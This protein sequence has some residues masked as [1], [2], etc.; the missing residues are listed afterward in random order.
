METSTLDKPWTQSQPLSIAAVSIVSS[1][2]LV[3][4]S[5]MWCDLLTSHLLRHENR[6]KSVW[7]RALSYRDYKAATA[8]AA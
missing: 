4:S 3:M 5:L 7:L 2:S 8:V 6:E 1:C